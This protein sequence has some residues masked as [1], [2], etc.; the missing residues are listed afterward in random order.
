MCEVAS[1]S[2]LRINSSNVG[3]LIG[4]LPRKDGM[5]VAHIL[6]I[7][8]HDLAA[9]IDFDAHAEVVFMLMLML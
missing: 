5:Q 4:G 2:R 3:R 6:I 7:V 8:A 9:E 1:F